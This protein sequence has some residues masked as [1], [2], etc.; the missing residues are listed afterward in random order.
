MYKSEVTRLQVTSGRDF[1]YLDRMITISRTFQ[2]TYLLPCCLSTSSKVLQYSRQLSAGLF[3][4]PTC[5]LV[6]SVLQVK[7]CSTPAEVLEY[8]NQSTGVLPPKYLAVASSIKRN[9]FMR[10]TEEIRTKL[11]N[12]TG[13]MADAVFFFIAHLGKSFFIAFGNEYRVI[14]KP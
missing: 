1:I 10:F 3:R 7:Y 9:R 12:R 4:R 2:K 11:L 5:C 8:F 13:T 14:S 6:V